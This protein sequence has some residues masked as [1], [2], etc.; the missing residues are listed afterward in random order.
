MVGT[1]GHGVIV[2][3]APRRGN[4]PPMLGHC[5]HLPLDHAPKRPAVFFLL[6]SGPLVGIPRLY[7]LAHSLNKKSSFYLQNTSKL[8]QSDQWGSLDEAAIMKIYKQVI[9]KWHI[10][11]FYLIG[12]LYTNRYSP[13]PRRIVRIDVNELLGG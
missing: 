1:T 5:W 10:I 6:F 4:F 7:Y 2:P 8:I 13:S 12:I 3:P 9:R 11:I